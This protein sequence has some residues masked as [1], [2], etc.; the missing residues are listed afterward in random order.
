MSDQ[1]RRLDYSNIFTIRSGHNNLSFG[2][3]VFHE[4]SISTNED[5]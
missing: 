5:T 1:I 4:W 2:T 3:Q